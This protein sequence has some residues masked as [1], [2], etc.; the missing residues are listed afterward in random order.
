MGTAI[1]SGFRKV[2]EECKENSVRVLG[3]VARSGIKE[4]ASPAGNAHTPFLIRIT[5][6]L[7]RLREEWFH[8]C[9]D[10]SADPGTSPVSHHSEPSVSHHQV[11]LTLARMPWVRA[12]AL[13]GPEL[14][15]KFT[16]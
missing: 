1:V 15:V 8:A 6:R 5:C 16:P 13:I 7:P 11:C 4:V 2:C 3:L 12:D 14:A 10:A 9:G